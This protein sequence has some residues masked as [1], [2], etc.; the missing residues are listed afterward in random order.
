MKLKH[1]RNYWSQRY[2]TEQ[3]GW[4]VGGPSTPLIT[5]FDRLVDKNIRIL[6][7]GAGRA[8]EAEYLHRMG[9][10][11]VYIADIAPEAI[12]QFK[13]RVPDFPEEHLLCVDFFELH[14]QFDLIV[15]QTFFC[16]LH[17]SER[18]RYCLQMHHLLAKGGKLAGLLF[19]EPLN[20]EHP[21][22]GGSREAYRLLFAKYFEIKTLET[23]Y[24]SISPRAG[25]EVFVLLHKKD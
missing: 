20:T 6:I 17:P 5:Y 22:Y 2:L 19:D 15:E 3:T 8:W 9:F 1:D 23:A 10:A 18:D 21:P 7:P 24:N 11:R 16:A 14:L 4:D 25:R 13:A 12:E